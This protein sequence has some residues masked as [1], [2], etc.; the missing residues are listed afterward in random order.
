[1]IID[2]LLRKLVV[3]LTH[4]KQFYIVKVCAWC[5][6]EE[7]PKLL[8]WQSYSHG[9]CKKHYAM[10]QKKNVKNYSHYDK[11]QLILDKITDLLF[12]K[13]TTFSQ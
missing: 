2:Y 8:M 1:M 9:I 6:K 11:I 7:Y 13:K 5:P 10:L 3:Y 12:P 4:R